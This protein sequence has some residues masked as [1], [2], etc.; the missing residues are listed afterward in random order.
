MKY[1]KYI[2]LL[3]IPAAYSVT[4]APVSMAI[5][6]SLIASLILTSF[7]FTTISHIASQRLMNRKD[8]VILSIE[9]KRL[10]LIDQK[11]ELE[12]CLADKTQTQPYQNLVEMNN[13]YI[14]IIEDQ[15]KELKEMKM[16]IEKLYESLKAISID[17]NLSKSYS[18]HLEGL[19]EF[20]ESKTEQNF[21]S[22]R[23]RKCS[24]GIHKQRLGIKDEEEITKS[25]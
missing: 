8:R 21:V 5:L 6:I 23:Q 24:L 10:K 13:N 15:T 11:E 18:H 4:F 7:V 20:F 3:L 17:S 12:Q 1:L 19:P 9:D 16:D 2:N 25:V 14:G 22:K